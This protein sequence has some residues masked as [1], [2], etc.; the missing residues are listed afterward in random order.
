MIVLNTNA[1]LKATFE[2]LVKAMKVPVE[3]GGQFVILGDYLILHGR[4]RS[5]FFNFESRKVQTN[6]IDL[7]I[8][9]EEAVEIG[10]RSCVQNVLNLT[11]YAFGKWGMIRGIKVEQDYAQLN[12]IFNGVL[13][14][15]SIE[16]G[17][18]HEN[19][20]FYKGGIRLNYEDVIQAALEAEENA[21][22]GRAA[23]REASAGLWHKLIWQK[24]KL[25]FAKRD[26]SFEES[27]KNRLGGNFY[28]VGYQCPKCRKNLHMTVFPQGK[29]FR[30]ETTEGGVFL[31]R[32][33]ACEPCLRFYTP[34]PE[35]LLTEG[36]VYVMD[37]LKDSQA[38]EDYK[39]LLGAEGARTSN[40]KFNEFEEV[41]KRK[42]KLQIKDSPESL[43]E[44]CGRLEQMT[45]EKLFEAEGK[46]EE[47][48]FPANSVER[49]KERVQREVQKRRMLKSVD[50][51]DETVR[52]ARQSADRLRKSALHSPG[53]TKPGKFETDAK[54]ED[55]FPSSKAQKKKTPENAGE[56]S[57]SR[58]EA[59]KKRYAAKCRILD[60]LSPAQSAELKNELIRDKNL[61]DTE[62]EE[63]LKKITEKETRQ[64][65][66]WIKSLSDGCKGKSYAK[67]SNAIEEIKKT[68][69]P[70][71]EKEPVLTPLYEEK[72]RRGEAEASDLINK[73]PG[74]LNMKQYGAYMERL[75]SYPDVDLSPYRGFLEEK[76]KEALE[77]ELSG[78]VRRAKTADRRGLADCIEKLKEQPFEEAVLAPWRKELEERLRRI[79]EDSLA[80]LCDRADMTAEELMETYR[81]IEEGEF[82]P[83][84]KASAL[85]RLKK[86]L[87]RLK[88]EECDLL[89]RRFQSDLNGKIKENSRHH[90]YSAR[91]VL[92]KEAEPGEYQEIFYALDTY[93]TKR[94]MFEYPILVVDT[95]RDRSG[96][97]GMIL[98]PDHLFYRTM[99]NAFAVSVGEIKSIQSQS[100][101][102]KAGLFLERQNGTK[103]KI[104]YAVD[105]KELDAWSGSLDSFIHYL[106][107]K[108]ESRKVSYLAKEKHETICCFRCG[109][110]YRGGNICPKCG[111]K[112]N[113]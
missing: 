100:G 110:T 11:L 85:E 58:R 107:E 17:Y 101:F 29:E 93:G 22:E 98:T 5:L 12:A 16:P 28:M 80:N 87:E 105:K 75:K 68:D 6:L 104:P 70:A 19:F 38:Y 84:L 10:S 62:K 94:G 71:K 102:L 103:I 13:R 112:M 26:V 37:F 65:R 97:E 78:L 90:F 41:R 50:K 40:Y 45:D 89:V 39:G 51:A 36:D 57:F 106:Q 8:K 86:R 79:D 20:R 30:I 48:F 24:Q 52:R 76:K 53:Q 73:M 34:R 46:M 35:K 63:F 3:W 31:A 47:G 77:R 72:R 60:R 23:E 82:L 21:Q 33:Y 7:S 69:L 108:P 95:S 43:E 91:R 111:Y 1:G 27:Q 9:E 81:K 83:E 4:V 2:R 18:S 25:S 44:V 64:K 15:I 42:E 74:Q 109:H 55:A 32:A 56:I 59:A 61:Y 92:A 88:A 66:E 67:I 14:E 96:K 99:L 113:Q 49:W 54:R